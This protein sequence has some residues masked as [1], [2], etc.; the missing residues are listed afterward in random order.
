MRKTCLQSTMIVVT[1]C[2]KSLENKNCTIIERVPNILGG[3]LFPT[4]K[5]GKHLGV[6]VNMR[7]VKMRGYTK[8]EVQWPPQF[9]IT[10]P[11][12]SPRRIERAVVDTLGRGH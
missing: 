2:P 10:I 12:T 8:D 4:S 3:G 7:D 5:E 9:T 11:K 6:V 1:T